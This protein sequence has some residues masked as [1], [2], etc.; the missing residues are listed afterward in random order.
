M[1]KYMVLLLAMATI[2]RS[3]MQKQDPMEE[4]KSRIEE[5]LDIPGAHFGIAYKNIESGETCFINEKDNFH[6]ASTMKTPV[7]AELF[8]QADAGRFSMGDSITIQN[9]F[10]S[11][12]DSSEYSLDPADDSETE[13]YKRIGQQETIAKLAYQMIIKSSNLAT[14]LLIAFAMP[15]SIMATMKMIGANDMK[16][17]RG[18]EDTKAF[19][20]GMNNTTTAYDLM[21]LYEQLAKE[22]LVSPAASQQMINILLDQ[23]F[24]DIIP[25]QLPEGVKVAHKTGSITG[26]HHDSGIVILPDGR[27]Y[28]IVL[29]S[30]FNAPDEKKVIQ[31]MA[32]VSKLFYD[33]AAR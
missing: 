12:V 26:V 27:K 11:I 20:K 23:Q 30:R 13:L 9:S 7:L 32:G 18:V 29:L 22:K 5:K 6:A 28:V 14:N 33:H 25:A 15:D 1:K 17:L 24:S 4:L 31:A 8:R 19:E 10:K 16:V 21:L 3:C 2:A